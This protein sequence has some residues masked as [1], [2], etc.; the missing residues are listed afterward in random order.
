MEPL[1]ELEELL[2]RL[3]WEL[4]D[5]EKAMALGFLEDATVLVLAHGVPTW[6]AETAPQTAKTIALSAARRLMVNPDGNTQSRAGDET[7]A[8]DGIGEDAGSVYLTGNEK[9]LLARL[10][11]RGGQVFSVQTYSWGT[12]PRRQRPVSELR[13]V[14]NSLYVPVEG[15]KAPFPLTTE[16]T[17]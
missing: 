13:A 17:Q 4:D 8:W 2:K 15:D 9:K 14:D 12:R 3:D 16:A 11:G 7:L 6:T 10:T 1:V 5:D